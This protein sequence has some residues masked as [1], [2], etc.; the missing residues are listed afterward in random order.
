MTSTGHKQAS[1]REGRTWPFTF[2]LLNSDGTVQKR[3]I[4]GIGSPTAPFTVS[5]YR[6][7]YFVVITSATGQPKLKDLLTSESAQSQGP[8]S[9]HEEE[10][11]V[12]FRPKTY[13]EPA[14]RHTNRRT[15]EIQARLKG[16]ERVFTLEIYSI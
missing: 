14:T 7:H 1:G 12:D 5:D 4:A 3:W 2:H 9:L 16:E 13:V 11:A 6:G 10:V 8:L 15:W